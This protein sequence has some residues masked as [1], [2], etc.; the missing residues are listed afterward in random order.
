M[1]QQ[2]ARWTAE[3]IGAIASTFEGWLSEAQGR[4]LFD[5]AAATRGRGAIVEIGSWKGRSTAWLAAGASIAGQRVHAI[6]PHL[7][8]REDPAAN[9]LSEFMANIGRAGLAHA[10]EPLVMTSM[11]AAEKLTGQIE[12]LFIDGDH[13]Y[14]GVKRDADLWL[15]RLVDG[16]LV[17]FHDVASAGYSGPRR[18]FRRC[19]CW[20]PRFDSIRRI[21]SMVAA[22]R[23][24]RRGALAA[25]RGTVAG[26][27]LYVYDLK[28]LAR[29]L[30]HL[31][32]RT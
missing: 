6:D 23:T 20:S 8:S 14:E 2:Y 25:A 9:T 31:A 7:R 22:R 12:L 13:E 17:V 28:R 21:G 18:V 29:K 26:V 19:I 11:D 15:P 3:T 24:H 30:K 5:A 32:R 1:N 16:G 27:L 4:A 10:V